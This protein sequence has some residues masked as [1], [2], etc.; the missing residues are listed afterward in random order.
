MSLKDL[1]TLVIHPEDLSTEF[2]SPIYSRIPNKTI[3]RH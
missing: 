1:K 3:L 2:L